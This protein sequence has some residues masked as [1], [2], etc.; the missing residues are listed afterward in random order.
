MLILKPNNYECKNFSFLLCPKFEWA[1]SCVARYSTL[2]MSNLQ[3]VAANDPVLKTIDNGYYSSLQNN[4]SND[5]YSED[6]LI[7]NEEEDVDENINLLI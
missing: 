6:E 4:N 1:E 7:D 3:I 5:I 2:S